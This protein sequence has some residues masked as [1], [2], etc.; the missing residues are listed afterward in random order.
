MGP[1]AILGGPLEGSGDRLES[2]E[3][4]SVASLG[5]SAQIAKIPTRV[6]S[7]RRGG[8]VTGRGIS[9]VRLSGPALLADHS[10]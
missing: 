4:P 10:L 5:A 2:S 8:I 9:V 3:V 1:G 6:K 7:P